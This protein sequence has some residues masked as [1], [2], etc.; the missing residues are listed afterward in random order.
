[1]KRLLILLLLVSGVTVSQAQNVTEKT[2][3]AKTQL[4]FKDTHH[5]FGDI[6][7][8]SQ[9]SYTFKFKN[10]SKEPLLLSKPES[11]C[12][13]TVASWPKAPIMPGDS[14]EIKVTYNTS[15]EGAFNKTVVV[16]S[17]SN[18]PVVLHI[19]GRVV[20]RPAAMIPVKDTSNGATPEAKKE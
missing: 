13:C 14:S 2:K 4:L 5:D 15:F 11:S 7:K 6:F 10:S 9:G 17:N 20:E 19:R 3:N 18:N 12:G 8:G 1:M 16:N